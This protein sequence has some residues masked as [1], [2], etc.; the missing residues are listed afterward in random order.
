MYHTTTDSSS[1]HRLRSPQLRYLYGRN[2]LIGWFDFDQDVITI[3]SISISASITICS[4][5]SSATMI[6]I[7]VDRS[8]HG[9]MCG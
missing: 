6:R 4:T 3:C 9:G 8:R 7:V 2:V 5:S 1:S